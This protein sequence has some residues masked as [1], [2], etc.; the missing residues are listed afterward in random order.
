MRLIDAD[1]LKEKLYIADDNWNPVVTEKEIDEAPTVE[2]QEIITELQMEKTDLIAEL[3][4]LQDFCEKSGYQK[5]GRWIHNGPW[6]DYKCSV[7]QEYSEWRT[8]FCPECGSDMRGNSNGNS[9][10]N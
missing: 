7:C 3:K 4:S 9:Q 1:A 8:P 6:S 2:A 10:S 5:H